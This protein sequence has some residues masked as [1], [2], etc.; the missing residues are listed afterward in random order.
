MARTS[1]FSLT[2]AGSS[3]IPVDHHGH[4][5]RRGDIGTQ[6]IGADGRATQSGHHDVGDLMTPGSNARP[7]VTASSHWDGKPRIISIMAAALGL[8]AC[9]SSMVTSDYRSVCTPLHSF[10]AAVYNL[11]VVGGPL[12]RYAG[13]TAR[14][15]YPRWTALIISVPAWKLAPAPHPPAW[16]RRGAAFRASWRPRSYPAGEVAAL[17]PRTRGR[18]EVATLLSG[19]L[20]AAD[21]EGRFIPLQEA[22]QWLWSQGILRSAAPPSDILEFLRSGESARDPVQQILDRSTALPVWLRIT[23]LQPA[24]LLRPGRCWRWASTTP[25]T[26]KS[27]RPSGPKCRSS[28]PNSPA[29]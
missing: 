17:P 23:E 26:W 6:Q 5:G 29:A 8:V 4:V 2:N 25:S 24:A 19:G 3:V 14:R 13:D 9:C 22:Y 10:S 21:S 15:R 7:S 18:H 1:V 27:R 16:H 12:P 20:A 28:S 11:S